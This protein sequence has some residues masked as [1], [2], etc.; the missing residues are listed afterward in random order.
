[1]N[2]RFENKTGLLK[3]I[4]FWVRFLVV[5]YP[6]NGSKMFPPYVYT[7]LAVHKEKHT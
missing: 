4:V 5:W 2:S 7:N 6:E 1:M 3:I